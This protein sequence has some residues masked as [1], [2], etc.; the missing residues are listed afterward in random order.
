MYTNIA[1]LY[2]TYKKRQQN[3]LD[4]YKRQVLIIQCLRRA[5]PPKCNLLSAELRA[6]RELKRDDSIVIVPA[7]KGS[8]TVVLNTE[9]YQRKIEGLLD[10]VSYTHL[11]VYKRQE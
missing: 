10:P 9:D 2:V 11:D 4:V 5:A 1:N 3:L 8:A 7:D 6:L